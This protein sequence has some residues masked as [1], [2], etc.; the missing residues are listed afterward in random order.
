MQLLYHHAFKKLQNLVN[1]I[2][3]MEGKS[4]IFDILCFTISRKLKMQVKHTQKMCR[5]WRRC[6]VW[7]NMSFCAEISCVTIFHGWEGQLKLIVIKTLIENS[8]C[9][10]MQEITGIFRIS[11]SSIE[12]ISTSL[13]MSI[14]LM[15]GFHISRKKQNKTSWPYF[16]MRFPTEI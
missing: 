7:L 15:S 5:V 13:V 3:K 4:N 9:Y 10:V 6:S 1:L 16:Q 2:L 8:Q 11:K 12:V 14:T